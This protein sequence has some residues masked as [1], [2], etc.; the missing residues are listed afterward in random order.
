MVQITLFRRETEKEKVWE[1]ERGTLIFPTWQTQCR[2]Q[3]VEWHLGGEKD[4]FLV[5]FYFVSFSAQFTSVSVNWSVCL[6]VKVLLTGAWWKNSPPWIELDWFYAAISTTNKQQTAGI[7]LRRISD[8]ATSDS[9]S[10]VKGQVLVYVLAANPLFQLRVI[11]MGL[12]ICPWR[13]SFTNYCT[14]WSY[15]KRKMLHVFCYSQMFPDMF[16]LYKSAT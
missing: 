11:R 14:F 4:L 6:R 7:P 10:S 12:G 2:L 1:K 3:W 15:S 13:H 9:L 5:T 16:L 8:A